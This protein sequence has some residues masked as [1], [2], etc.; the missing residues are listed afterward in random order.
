M[1]MGGS[2]FGFQKRFSG[3]DAAAARR[4]RLTS[5]DATLAPFL[6][7]RLIF[8]QDFGISNVVILFSAPTVPRRLHS[9][10]LLEDEYCA[11]D[12][13]AQPITMSVASPVCDSA[14]GRFPDRTC[15]PIFL[16]RAGWR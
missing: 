13:A 9:A 7:L 8:G 4:R 14:V 10:L 5:A 12:V 2:S 11:A 3:C 16:Y 1:G 6:V 15:F